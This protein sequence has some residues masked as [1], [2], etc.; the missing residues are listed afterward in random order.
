MDTARLGDRGARVGLRVFVSHASDDRDAA[1]RIHEWLAGLGYTVFLA[2]EPVG[3]TPGGADWVSWLHRELRRADAVVA[4]LSAAYTE[5]NWCAAEIAVAA[6]RGCLV[7]PVRL[8]AGALHP[9]LPSTVQYV[10][11]PR[12]A[13]GPA[14]IR[15]AATLA[16]LDAVGGWGW[17]D[18]LSPYPGLAAFDSSRVSVF[19]GRSVEIKEVSERLR[20]VP[21]T[22]GLIVVGPSGCGKS[23]LVRAGVAPALAREQGWLVAP[24]VGPEGG[25]SA[26]RA[27]A[28][29]LA[30]LTDVQPSELLARLTGPD[31]LLDLTDD[32]LDEHGCRRLLLVLDQLEELLLR[33]P[34]DDRVMLGA[35]IR[36]A[37]AGGRV[38]VL[39]TARAEYLATVMSGPEFASVDLGTYVLRPLTSEALRTVIEEPAERAGLRVSRDLTD[40]LVADTGS[41]EALPLLAFT[42]ARLARDTSRGDELSTTSYERMGGVRG[43]L[44]DQAETAIARATGITGRSRDEIVAILVDR[45][46]HLDP[47]DRPTRRRADRSVLAPESAQVLDHFV[48]ARL[49]STSV[50]RSDT[51]ATWYGVTHEALFTAWPPLDAAIRERAQALRAQQNADRAAQIWRRNDRQAADLWDGNRL[52]AALRDLGVRTGRRRM[53]TQLELAVDTRE[54]LSAS[55]RRERFRRGRIAGVLSLLLVVAVVV[56]G[57]AVTQQ[58]AAQRQ[59]QIVESQRLAA[60]SRELFTRADSALAYDPVTALKLGVAARQISPDIE[61]AV[62]LSVLMRRTALIGSI[63]AAGPNGSLGVAYRPDGRMLAE[64]SYDPKVGLRLW[65]VSRP[66]RPT[67]LATLAI[68]AQTRPAVSHDGTFIA[69]GFDHGVDERRVALIDVRDPRHPRTTSIVPIP[70]DNVIEGVAVSPDDRYLAAYAGKAVTLWDIAQPTAPVRV[71][72]LPSD[73]KVESIYTATGAVQFSHS[74]RLLAVGGDGTGVRLWD[75]ADPR[76]PRGLG[77]FPGPSSEFNASDRV[78]A[79]EFSADDRRLA[80]GKADSTVDIWDVQ[81]PGRP[82]LLTT[83]RGHSN[84]VASIVFVPHSDLMATGSLDQTVRL[85]ELPAGRPVGVLRGSTSAVFQVAVNPAGTTLATSGSDTLFWDPRDPTP[86][87]AMFR[88]TESQAA[89]STGLFTVAALRD[90]VYAA[91]GSGRRIFYWTAEGLRSTRLRAI[92]EDPNENYFL[93]ADFAV[94]RSGRRLAAIGSGGVVLWDASTPAAPVPGAFLPLVDTARLTGGDDV[95][96]SARGDLLAAAAADGHVLVWRVTDTSHAT[97]IAVLPGSATHERLGTS[98]VAFSPDG[99]TLATL[100]EDKSFRLWRLSDPARP[101]LIRTTKTGDG[102]VSRLA[103]SPDGRLLAMTHDGQV[104]LWSGT[105]WSQRIGTITNPAGPISEIAFSPD[106]RTLAAVGNGPTTKLY[107]VT[108]PADVPEIVALSGPTDGVTDVAFGLDGS[109]VV[110]TGRDTTSW[111]WNVRRQLHQYGEQVVPAACA[112]AAGGFS[113]QEWK[114]TIR[115]L[116]Y[117]PTCPR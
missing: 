37:V 20:A 8:E 10:D 54:F 7:V 57:Y 108:N 25:V 14:A 104:I 53:E 113:E 41:G 11:F 9:L 65:D 59:Q 96:L 40:R 62:S 68:A 97:R 88:P 85:W 30:T 95:E 55:V 117:R 19:C 4:L 98:A 78:F 109:T 74:G 3:G 47:E 70:P 67:L 91:G 112:A 26:L 15:L 115:D 18:D 60:V 99:R 82:R 89:G 49:V 36:A 106:S 87:G 33:T 92:Q 24:V 51:P 90:G 102:N 116:E 107:D 80:V 48:D 35:A 66:G 6:S 76:H 105:S 86:V 110:V 27:L 39:G 111:V 61:S 42:L 17:E 16:R 72:T 75:L 5:S 103:F 69:L 56:A 58:L 46:V 93:V 73:A 34:H 28:R 31:G 100:G 79:V 23:S 77:G 45:L 71:A 21:L 1:G 52:A 94:D 114:E 63:P 50:D 29:S 38:Q 32:L 12:E 81:R 43:A 83:L 44:S 2:D 22:P 84:T 101:T 64:T 13:D